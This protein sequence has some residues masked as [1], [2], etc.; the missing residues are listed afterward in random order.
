MNDAAIR[1][2]WEL[3]VGGQA[4]EGFMRLVADFRKLKSAVVPIPLDEG[5]FAACVFLYKVAMFK[6]ASAPVK[7]TTHK[8]GV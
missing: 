1:E 5:D 6:A 3:S 8:A 2:A 7:P 4:P